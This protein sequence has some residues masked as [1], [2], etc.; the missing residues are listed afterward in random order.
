MRKP[1]HADAELLLR[2]YEIRREPELRQARAW[3]LTDFKPAGWPEIKTR[4]I[5][6]SEEDRHFRMTVSYWE[7]VG[8]LVNSG[9]VH[10]GLFFDHTGEDIV[11]WD[12][13]KAWIAEARADLRPNYLHQFET[14]VRDHLAYR[15]KSI[16]AYQAAQ[17][18][19][20]SASARTSK[21]RGRR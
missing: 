9:V 8:T 13:C 19:T 18:G 17:R 7:M 15:V 21:R 6:H 16:A 5:S 4:Y 20:P 12:R 1:T 2:L 11:T 10:P 3:F 14:L